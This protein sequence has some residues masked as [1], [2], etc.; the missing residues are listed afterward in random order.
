MKNESQMQIYINTT[1]GKRLYT[2]LLLLLCMHHT[3]PYKYWVAVRLTSCLATQTVCGSN[4]RNK[5]NCYGVLLWKAV[6]NWQTTRSLQRKSHSEIG[7]DVDPRNLFLSNCTAG[8]SVPVYSGELC[9][10]GKYES[11]RQVD[12]HLD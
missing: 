5:Y 7:H 2:P 4:V 11:L 8:Y 3:Q 1:H 12:E 6:M 10:F 9:L